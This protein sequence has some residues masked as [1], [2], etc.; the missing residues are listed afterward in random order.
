M[1]DAAMASYTKPIPFLF[2]IF[3]TINLILIALIAAEKPNRFL[4][5]TK[6]VR[7]IRSRRST[8]TDFI[9]E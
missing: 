4:G 7:P 8:T 3:T 2:N 1:F 6:S 5:I 9:S